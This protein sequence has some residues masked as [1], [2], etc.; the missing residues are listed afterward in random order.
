MVTTLPSMPL[1]CFL[2]ASLG[3]LYGGDAMLVPPHYTYCACTS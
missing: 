3:S 1:L 2:L